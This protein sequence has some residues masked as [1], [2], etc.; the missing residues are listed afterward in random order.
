MTLND[1]GILRVSQNINQLIV[2]QEVE[3]WES[4]SLQSHIIIKRLLNFIKGV[5]VLCQF[6]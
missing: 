4:F 2:R 3:S 1:D 5:V 6:I